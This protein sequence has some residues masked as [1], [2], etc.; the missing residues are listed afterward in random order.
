MRK[1]RSWDEARAHPGILAI[2]YIQPTDPSD[3]DAPYCVMLKDGWSFQQNTSVMYVYSLKD[4]QS[5]WVDIINEP[6]EEDFD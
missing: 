6:Y 2:E 3:T 1:P 4:F 5:L